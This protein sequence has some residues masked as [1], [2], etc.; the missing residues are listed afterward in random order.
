MTIE[1]NEERISTMSPA[2]RLAMLRPCLIPE[3]TEVHMYYHILKIRNPADRSQIYWVKVGLT[4]NLSPVLNEGHPPFH[5]IGVWQCSASLR[6]KRSQLDPTPV[7]D[8][9]EI[10]H[11][12]AQGVIE[13]ALN[14]IGATPR[15]NEVSVAR[16]G[17]TALHLFLACNLAEME[18]IGAMY[19][20]APIFR[21]TATQNP[22][23]TVH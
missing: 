1:K 6:K 3:D 7:D 13:G 4:L 23:P 20:F 22:G 9:V 11:Q 8:W 21:K 15:D 17:D 18:I 14:G 10:E 5:G 19:P 16:I 12:L 2:Q